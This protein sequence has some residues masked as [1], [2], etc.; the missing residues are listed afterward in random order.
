M[1][2]II[3]NLAHLG[4]ASIGY[5][6][7]LI[8]TVKLLRKLTDKYKLINEDSFANTDIVKMI[9]KLE[10]ANGPAAAKLVLR[11]MKDIMIDPKEDEEAFAKR[12]IK[13]DIQDDDEDGTDWVKVYSTYVSLKNSG[14]PLMEGSDLD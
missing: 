2:A 11:P 14:S 4:G 13:M 8:D 1:W 10:K 7:T 3:E 6:R 9:E 5:L 12:M